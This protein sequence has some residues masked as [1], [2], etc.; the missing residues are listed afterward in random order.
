M[1][2]IGHSENLGGRREPLREHLEHVA[3]K[4]EAFAEAF[5]ANEQALAAGLL[6]DLRK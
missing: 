2:Y 6:H 5:G 1:E 3:K 4:S